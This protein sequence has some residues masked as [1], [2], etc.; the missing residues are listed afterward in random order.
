MTHAAPTPP[1]G[2]SA[3]WLQLREPF[4]A[5][6]RAAAVA[7]PEMADGLA[8]LRTAR[9]TSPLQVLDL[10]CGLGAN[11]RE[12]APRLG[13]AQHWHLL[14]HDAALLAALPAALARWSA[15]QGYAFF[16][17]DTDERACRIV[18]ADFSASVSWAC[19][20]LARHAAS[21]PFAAGALITASA[22]LDLVSAAWLQ[23][24]VQR[25]RDGGAAMYWALS[26]DGRAQWTPADRDDAAVH[27]LFDAHQRRDKGFGP[28]LG[29]QAPSAALGLLAA[30]GYRCRTARADW[31]IDDAAAAPMRQAMI[32]GSAA[33]AREQDPAAAARIEAWQARRSAGVARSRL[34]VGH[35]DIL[36]LPA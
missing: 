14:D 8:R 10:A 9:G 26:V 5:A 4:D 24:L 13:G 31:H 7:Q 36:A 2:F 29:P 18:G 28:A 17:S 3:E 20:G 22:L 33:A 6:A 19:V 1:S 12:L 25:A 23:P 15:R 30:A 32:D 21:L 34:Q 27:T 16:A 35:L 11:L